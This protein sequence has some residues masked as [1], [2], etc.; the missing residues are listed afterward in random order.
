MKANNL[1]EAAPHGW[2]EQPILAAE[3][4]HC[5]YRETSKLRGKIQGF[6]GGW[7]PNGNIIVRARENVVKNQIMMC[8]PHVEVESMISV[9]QPR[10][11]CGDH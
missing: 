1:E 11:D 9:W 7:T 6:G 4:P 8:V 3:M 10:E 2:R 5:R